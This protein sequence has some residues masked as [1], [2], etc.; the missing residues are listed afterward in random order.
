[1]KYFLKVLQFLFFCVSS[2]L[3]RNFHWGFLLP[4]SFSKSML[5]AIMRV[6]SSLVWVA[7]IPWN[8]S[9]VLFKTYP[10]IAKSYQ[11][12]NILIHNIFDAI[13]KENTLKLK[14]QIVKGFI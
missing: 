2:A 6:R 14:E 7:R 3:K 13:F 11:I 9:D 4:Y 5:V 10:I 1:M 8:K 12:K